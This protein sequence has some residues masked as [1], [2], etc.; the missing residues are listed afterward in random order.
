MEIIKFKG[1]GC[2]GGDIVDEICCD[3]MDSERICWN[4][5]DLYM[6]LFGGYTVVGIC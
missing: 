4:L 6:N 5:F 2:F 3:L 1:F